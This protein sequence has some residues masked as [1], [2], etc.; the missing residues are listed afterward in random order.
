MYTCWKFL[1]NYDREKGLQEGSYRIRSAMWLFLVYSRERGNSSPL[2]DTWVKGADSIPP[3]P[4]KAIREDNSMLPAGASLLRWDT[5]EDKGGGKTLGFR[6]SY[7]K[8][9]QEKVI[10]AYLVP[11]ADKPGE[12][13]RMHIQDIPFAPGEDTQLTVR[14]VDSSGNAGQP[15][16][17]TIR[18][19]SGGIP[20]P[21]VPA[22]RL[23]PFPSETMC[24]RPHH[25]GRSHNSDQPDGRQ[26]RPEQ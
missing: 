15:V 1:K 12:E 17:K 23:S 13:V 20:L 3:D 4:V 11:M 9:N 2:L 10:P 6:V 25:K 16:S 8:G 5:S 18:V 19:S 7:K 26:L 14:P 24:C 22:G 21:D